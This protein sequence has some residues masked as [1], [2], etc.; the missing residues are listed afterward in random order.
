MFANEIL[1]DKIMNVSMKGITVWILRAYN[2]YISN[3]F[4]KNIPSAT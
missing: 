2:N 4:D 1:V 3:I